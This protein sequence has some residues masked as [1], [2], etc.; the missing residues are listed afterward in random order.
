[1]NTLQSVMKNMLK[2]KDEKYR[3]LKLDNAKV[4]ERIVD[5]AGATMFLKGVGFEILNEQKIMQV[6]LEK[7]NEDNIRQGLAHL[8]EVKERLNMGE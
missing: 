3:T 4:H 1:M 8:A 2:D 6:K 7:Y 5:M